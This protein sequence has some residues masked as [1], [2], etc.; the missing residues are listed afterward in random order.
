MPRIP[1]IA[2]APEAIETELPFKVWENFNHVD[3]VKDA[4]EV[5][6]LIWEREN[7]CMQLYVDRTIPKGDDSFREPT[8]LWLAEYG[9]EGE[10][11]REFFFDRAGVVSSSHSTEPEDSSELLEQMEKESPLPYF[12]AQKIVDR[13]ILKGY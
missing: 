1:K 8:R 6:G 9:H 10:R 2:S 4:N 12:L 7:G 5:T 3:T 11:M 13:V